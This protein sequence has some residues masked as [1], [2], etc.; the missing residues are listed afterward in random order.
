M[1]GLAALPS[2]QAYTLL[3]VGSLI[4]TML[5]KLAAGTPTAHT[6]FIALGDLPTWALFLGALV[7]ALIALRQLKIQQD[8]SVRQ[9]QQLERQQANDVDFTWCPATSVLIRTD[10]SSTVTT[11]GGRTVVVVA[12]NSRR[13]IRDVSCWIELHK[14]SRV[15]EPL[16]LGPIGEAPNAT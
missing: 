12:N 14:S 2:L 11:T 4:V 5:T 9:T 3:G 15:L 1:R 7:A 6:F 10:P 16:M 13:P 8:D